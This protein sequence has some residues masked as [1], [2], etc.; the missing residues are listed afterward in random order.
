[1]I[2]REND[3]G[4][5]PHSGLADQVRAI[6][7]EVTLPLIPSRVEQPGNPPGLRVNSGD[8]RPL[9]S[10]VM[11]ARQRKIVERCGTAMLT[12]DDIVDWKW[13]CRIAGLRHPAILA[14][15]PRSLPHFLRE[16]WVHGDVIYPSW[17]S[18]PSSPSIGATPASAPP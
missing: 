10:I 12:R 1:M 15:V 14:G 4:R 3:E 17:L 16:R 5:S 9:V 7:P 2:H 8:V 11:Q 13:H 18:A 6:P